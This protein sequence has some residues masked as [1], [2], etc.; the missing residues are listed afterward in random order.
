[1]ANRFPLI[2]NESTRKIEEIIS[3][4]NIDLTG[5]GIVISGSNG[6][7]GQYLK[8]LGSGAMIWDSPGDVYTTGAQTIDGKTFTNA[9]ISGSSNILTNIPNSALVNPSITLN[10]QTVALGGSLSVQ[11]TNTT[12]TVS[13]VDGTVAAKKIIRL[14]SGGT[15]AGVDDDVTLVAGTNVTLDRTEDEITINSTFTDTDTVTTVESA[16][17]G[18]SVSGQIVIDADG[19]C[20]VSQTGNTIKITGSDS[21]TK[22]NIRAGTGQVQQTGDFTFLEAGAM[23]L[24][25][26][27]NSGTGEVEITFDSQDTI[28]RVKGGGSGSFQS[29]DILVSGGSSGNVTVS[30]SGNTVE[31]DSLNDNTVTGIATGTDVPGAGNFR[32][33]QAGATTITNEGTDSD[34]YTVI[35]IESANDD[36]GASLNAGV[37]LTL[38]NAEF[39]IKNQG[40]LTN[41]RITKWDATNGQFINSIVDDNGSV[42]TINGDLTVTGTN[43]ILETSTLLVEDNLIELRKGNNLLAANLQ[44]GVQVNRTTDSSGAVTSFQQFQWFENGGY[45]RS[46][47]GSVAR[48]FVTEDEIQTLTNKTLTSPNLTTPNLGQA[49]A[50]SINS[51]AIANNTGATLDIAVAKTLTVTNTLGFTGTDGSSV[52]FGNGTA[53]SARV[54]YSSDTL[55]VFASTTSTQL[56]G[57]IT[58]STGTNKNVFSQDPT[59]QIGLKTDSTT[60]NVINTSATTVNAFGAATALNMGTSGGMTTVSGNLTVTEDLTVGGI[61]GDVLLV[62]ATANFEESDILIRGNSV[63]PI[64]IGRGGNAISSNT[65]VGKEA[66]EVNSNGINNSAFGY[67]ALK[68][69]ESGYDNLGVG[70]KAGRTNIAGIENTLIGNEA[71]HDLTPSAAQQN[72]DGRGN[73]VVGFQGLFSSTNGS[74]NTIIGYKAGYAA[75]GSGNVIIG[76]SS[77]SNAADAVYQPE[78][79]SGDNQL[80]IAS[81]TQAWIRGDSNFDIKIPNNC[82]IFG[83]AIIDGNLTVNGETTTINAREISVDDKNIVLGDV[84]Q[85]N[86]T[87]TVNGSAVLTG[88]TPMAGLLEGM[89]VES[90]STVTVPTGT[91]IQSISGNTVT[92]SQ[93]VSGASGSAAFVCKGPTEAAANGGGIILKGGTPSAPTN[94]TITYDN[95]RVDKYWV[96]SE[97]LELLTGKKFVIGNQLAL[98]STTLGSTVVNS[99]LTSVGTLT[100]LDVNGNSELGGRVVEKTLGTWTSTLTPNAGVVTISLATSNTV[101]YQPSANPITEW[102]FTNLNLD[103]NRAFTVTL[104][105]DANTA[106]TYGDAC[107]VD[108]ASI[109]TGVQWSGGSPPSPTANVDILTF[110]IVKDGNGD[111]KVFGQGNTDFS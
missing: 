51:L 22:T 64:K 20:Q 42:V 110:L 12:Y 19:S 53:G 72:F 35:K 32:F 109:S 84:G 98:S 62:N 47:D 36:T 28:T 63:A 87:C 66:L 75:L 86:I 97:N 30:Q 104:I 7:P 60:F 69:V 111:V 100:G 102:R 54:A 81:G 23:T 41:N 79:A 11:D 57:V 67:E 46:F 71:A 48:R 14:T 33:Q 99:S 70:F 82:S 56:L 92:L 24:S 9:N 6:T 18:S 37:G 89:E 8:T 29:G 73:V 91:I 83:N 108:G 10:G 17:G 50:T 5:N 90:T 39:S 68:S 88:V 3:G 26:T 21:D 76:A 85:V 31:I 101:L 93:V 105:L 61:P 58:D 38:N 65:R 25:Q 1:M 106:A 77:N 40:N 34:G 43:T 95:T 2:V 107:Q 78:S 74:Y 45:W 55:A 4:D 94:K 49:T 44:S 15:N 103:P 52:N 16:V 96:M 13:A 80:I 59:F 27:T